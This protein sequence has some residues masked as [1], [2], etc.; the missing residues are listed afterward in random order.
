MLFACV[1]LFLLLGYEK[2]NYPLQEEQINLTKLMQAL[3]KLL[4]K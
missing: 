3:V 1:I 2:H 4:I